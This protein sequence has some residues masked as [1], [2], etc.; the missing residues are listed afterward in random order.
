MTPDASVTV[1]K[2]LSTPDIDRLDVEHT[3]YSRLARPVSHRRV[4]QINKKEPTWEI[5][6]ILSGQGEHSA[7]W[8]FHFDTEIDFESIG[9]G[10]FRTSCDGTNIEIV[11]QSETLLRFDIEDGWISRWYGHKLPAK[12]LH[13]SGNFTS[14]CRMQLTLRGL[15]AVKVTSSVIHSGTEYRLRSK[16][17]SRGY[18]PNKN[19][20]SN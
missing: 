5:S 7:D 13:M 12:I 19:I 9:E 18:S 6:D 17:S 11:V 1:H 14:F 4:F 2:W 15:Q 10:V 3:G 20:T 8:Y 16:N